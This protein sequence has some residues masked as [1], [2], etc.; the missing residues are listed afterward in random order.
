VRAALERGERP[1]MAITWGCGRLDE[2]V[3]PHGE[4]GVL[5]ALDALETTRERAGVP[6]ELLLRTAATLSFLAEA[7]LSGAAQTLFAEPTILLQLG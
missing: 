1:D 6:D 7:S 4:L 3:A 2:L 5:G